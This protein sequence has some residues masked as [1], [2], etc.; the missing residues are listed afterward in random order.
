VSEKEKIF[1]DD[2]IPYIVK[3]GRLTNLLAV[4]ISFGPLIV[5]AVGFN[6]LP[7]FSTI[8]AGAIAI[9]SAVAAFW[10]VE[11]ISYYPIL[12]IPGTYMSFLAGNISNL[13]LP[14]AAV[15]QESAGV[16]PG[17]EEG[18]I[19]ST[20]GIATSIIIN[21]LFLTFGVLAGAA[22]LAA[23]PETVRS[24]FD[25]IL[26]ALFGAIFANFAINR[27]KIGVIAL[28]FAFIMT[29]L[30]NRGYLSFL[31]GIPSY[32]VIIVSVFGTIYV[33]RKLFEK[34]LIK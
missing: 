20:L 24:A 6:L 9:W 23:L 32:A 7:E 16:E 8:I 28:G 21:I 30:M 27:P 31:P 33:A 34:G 19:I 3:W 22:V 29:I 10:F 15:A 18:S 12:G 11:P 17:S 26:P 13:R 14:C 5:L 1:N 4:V 2:Y 25:Y